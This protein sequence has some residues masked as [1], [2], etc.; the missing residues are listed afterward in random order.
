M[1][2]IERWSNSVEKE[3]LELME[4]LYGVLKQE[5]RQTCCTIVPPGHLV[6]RAPFCI[7]LLRLT[8]SNVPGL[9]DLAELCVNLEYSDM[10]PCEIALT[11]H[12]ILSD[13]CYRS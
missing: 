3:S 13:L 11:S 4:S 1:H 5:R 6:F 9:R 2:L 8:R 12:L 7:G 10:K